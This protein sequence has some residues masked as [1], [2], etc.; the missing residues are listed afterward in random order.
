MADEAVVKCTSSIC[1]V[2]VPA[3]RVRDF[4][5]VTISYDDISHAFCSLD[6]AT[7][8][9]FSIGDDDGDQY[10]STTRTTPL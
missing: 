10:G 1:E 7:H 2:Q 4:G 3:A 6:C 5:F 9:I 8:W